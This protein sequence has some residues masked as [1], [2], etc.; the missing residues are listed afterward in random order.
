M[1]FNTKQWILTQQTS[2]IKPWGLTHQEYLT[3]GSD[4]SRK[5]SYIYEIPGFAIS[6]IVLIPHHPH[7]PSCT[8][9]IIGAL[10]SHLKKR[11]GKFGIVRFRGQ[12]APP[13]PTQKLK[14]CSQ[15]CKKSISFLAPPLSSRKMWNFFLNWTFDYSPPLGPKFG[16]HRTPSDPW[17]NT[18]LTQTFSWS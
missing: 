14:Q 16:D 11:F 5:Y 7:P 9:K 3:H 18:I 8:I 2:R 10:I 1:K 13:E 17:K 15:K 4:L 12:L 6:L